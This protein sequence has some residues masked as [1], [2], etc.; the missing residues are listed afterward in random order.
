[1][2]GV[3]VGHWTDARARTGCTAVVLP[4][5]TTASGEIRGGAPASRDFAL[6]D[7]VRTV[8]TVDAIVLSGGSAFGL[9]AADGVMTVLEAQGR[10]FQASAGPVPIVVGLSLYD[11]AVGDGSVRPGPAE[12]RIA[13]EAAAPGPYPTG[14]VGAGIGATVG[15]WS[16][17]PTPGGLGTATLRSGSTVVSALVAVNA[18]G[19]IDDGTSV[20]DIGPP[21]FPKSAT[22]GQAGTNTTIGVVVTNAA[23]DKR[24]C[25]LM[26]QSAHD[27]LARALLPAHTAVDGDGFV[28][29]ATGT[30]EVPA[31]ADGA[32][33]PDLAHLRML[34]QAAVVRSVRAVGAG[35][36]LG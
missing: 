35:D 9:A 3:A 26:A 4:P 8:T 24:H 22:D 25:H 17:Q 19:F 12:G 15:K 1:M 34:A 23:L 33:E 28:V 5:G 13:A 18:F 27:G 30:R 2:P 31:G 20:D 7:P 10:G 6:L 32:P 14:Q 21:A 36:P 16:G 11:L 29:A